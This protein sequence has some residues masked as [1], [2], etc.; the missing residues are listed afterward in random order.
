MSLKKKVYKKEQEPFRAAKYLR[1]SDNLRVIPL[2]ASG[3]K[4]A[5]TLKPQSMK[6]LAPAKPIKKVYRPT[7][8]PSISRKSAL[9]ML[10]MNGEKS[11]TV[12][13]INKIKSDLDV[14]SDFDKDY[15]G[16]KPVDL[17]SV[18]A[19]DFTKAKTKLVEDYGGPDN[20]DYRM[21]KGDYYWN[22]KKGKIRA[23]YTEYPE[24]A[25]DIEPRYLGKNWDNPINHNSA[26]GRDHIHS[27]YH[28]SYKGDATF[29]K[30]KKKGGKVVKGDHGSKKGVSKKSPL[31]NYQ[32]PSGNQY[33][34]NREDF[35]RLQND[36]TGAIQ[37]VADQRTG[38]HL[39]ELLKKREN[40]NKSDGV[41]RK[42]GLWDNIHAKRKRIKAGSGEKMR[43]PGSKGA[44]SAKDLKDSQNKK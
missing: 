36:I 19:S 17:G 1:K 30:D 40:A 18:Q 7:E 35:Q 41:S 44:P 28:T 32:S 33:F 6:P 38:K 25:G 24:D 20:P 3:F 13:R 15:S 11:K 2:K 9:N 5:P 39:D 14:K 16:A 29:P 26:S 37:N 43:K 21:D 31:N 23:G 34:S 12:G 10:G 4:T 42:K 22:E 8:Y 27:K